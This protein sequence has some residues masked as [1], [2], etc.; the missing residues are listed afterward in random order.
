[1]KISK[2]AMKRTAYL[3]VIVFGGLIFAWSVLAA[4]SSVGFSIGMATP[5]AAGIVMIAWAIYHIK[6]DKPI[7]KIK[8]L[9][10][11]FKVC[12]CLVIAAILVLELLIMAAAGAKPEKAA[13]TVI[14]LGCGIFPD[15][16]LTLTLANRL[17][18]AYDY[19]IAHPNTKV[20]V[21]GGKGDNE[22]IA[23]A[24]AMQKYLVSRG[25]DESRV[26]MED[27][28]TSTEENI[29]GVL[30]IMERYGLSRNAAVVTSDYHVFRAIQTA[31][32][33]G[34]RAFGIPSPTPWRVL[35]SN[36]VRE[37]LA[38]VKTAFLHDLNIDLN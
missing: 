37:W 21:S 11:A 18:A 29:E 38:I 35:L 34:L 36:H 4:I 5:A 30:E 12:V 31:R 20:V 1:M 15:G 2:K 8:W 28:S 33:L 25:I 9:R 7:I 23:E 22:P 19:L 26:Y 13:D 17:G 24:A 27:K 10:M 16:R 3:A 6:Y 14:V 32:Q